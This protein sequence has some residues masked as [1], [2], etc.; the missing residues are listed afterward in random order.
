MTRGQR[1]SLLLHCSGLPPPTPCR[2]YRRTTRILA[3]VQIHFAEAIPIACV[4]LAVNIASAWLLSSGGHHHGHSHGGHD[5][6]AHEEAHPIAT[7]SG[8]LLLEVFEDGVPPRFRLRA[9]RAPTPDA[10]TTRIT[11]TR[12]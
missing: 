2:F 7:R 12:P 1:G 10:A 9:A 6:H 4:G 3:P 8:D 11:T 5:D